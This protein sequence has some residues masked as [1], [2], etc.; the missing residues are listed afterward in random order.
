[1][2]KII[3]FV[4]AL[5]LAFGVVYAPAAEKPKKD[6]KVLCCHDGKCDG[7]HDLKECIK[8]GG[9]IVKSCKDCK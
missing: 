1:M 3:L 4:L 5:V 8:L 6:G 9:K 7:H 2:K